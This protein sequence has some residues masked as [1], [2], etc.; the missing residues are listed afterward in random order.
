LTKVS[1]ILTSYNHA[2]YLPASIESVLNQTFQDFELIIVDD[3]ST[4]ESWSII[5]RYTDPRIQTCQNSSNE[6]TVYGINK[7]ISERASGEYIAIH[8]S[9]D[10]WDPSKLEKQIAYLD[11]HPEV[12]AVFTGLTPVNE[13]G[14]SFTDRSRFN[15]GLFDQPNRSRYEWLYY[16]FRYGNALCHPSVLIRKICYQECG[17]Y[18]NGMVQLPDFDMWVRLCLKFE[19]H[20]MAE[21]LVLFRVRENMANSSSP[22]IENRSRSSFEFLQILDNYCSLTS[23]EEIVKVFPVA[24]EYYSPQG[25]DP[26]FVLAMVALETKAHI[27]TALFGL[28]LLFSALNDPLRAEKIKELYDFDTLEFKR[29]SGKYDIFSSNLRIELAEKEQALHDLNARFHALEAMTNSRAW[30]FTLILRKIL[31]RLIP[32]ARH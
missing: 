26:L 8:H 5:Q 19:I 14:G 13:A 23:F 29:L 20:V 16:F 9:D 18:K 4:D 2:K 3:A 17:L 15:F 24:Q 30:K 10:M 27:F 28:N 21:K 22:T 31:Q 25:C 6:Y 1:V 7:A 11:H 12:G 32:R